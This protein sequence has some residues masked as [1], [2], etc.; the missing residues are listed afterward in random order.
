VTSVSRHH[1][2]SERLQMTLAP[3]SAGRGSMCDVKRFVKV[4]LL[5]DEHHLVRDCK[6][7]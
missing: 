1:P 6:A 7:T 4:V 2:G 3:S 5:S